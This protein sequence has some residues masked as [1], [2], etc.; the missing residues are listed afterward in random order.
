MS[1]HITFEQALELVSNDTSAIDENALV[2][3]AQ[4][5]EPCRLALDAF[6]T[7]WLAFP[8]DQWAG[9]E[10]EILGWLEEKLDLRPGT[11][12]ARL[13]PVVSAAEW[14]ARLGIAGEPKSV[15]RAPEPQLRRP[16][17]SLA[18]AS[19]RPASSRT[20]RG[21]G[22]PV[23]LAADSGAAPNQ[24]LEGATADGRVLWS[25]N[26]TDRELV[27]TAR[28]ADPRD[29]ALEGARLRVKVN[30][31]VLDEFPLGSSSVG[32]EG[33]RKIPRAALIK[34]LQIPL[35]ESAIPDPLEIE[36]VDQGRRE[37]G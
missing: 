7:R 35:L 25:A 33:S 8:A 21:S 10:A 11:G 5:C 28:A 27:V 15:E 6:L 30:G 12:P 26:L 14:R 36:M 32:P 2:E 18:A 4:S 3:H 17:L 9:K 22:G 37:G 31:V 34:A 1:D 24:P 23:R 19:K 29:G 16:T 20:G 13:R